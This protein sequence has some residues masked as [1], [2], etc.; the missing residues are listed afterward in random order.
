MRV[1]D[2]PLHTSLG[3]LPLHNSQVFYLSYEQ[4]SSYAWKALEAWQKASPAREQL[5]SGQ[6]SLLRTA[7]AS[8]PIPLTPTLSCLPDVLPAGGPLQRPRKMNATAINLVLA[9]ASGAYTMMGKHLDAFGHIIKPIKV[10][11]EQGTVF[12]TPPGVWHIDINES[13]RDAWIL[14][15]QDDMLLRHQGALDEPFADD[16][17]AILKKKWI[18]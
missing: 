8:E 2:A 17:V 4:L 6:G 11:W 7:S 9:A 13:F 16:E 3:V 5:D 10:D 12:L 14:H 15:L 1:T 18:S